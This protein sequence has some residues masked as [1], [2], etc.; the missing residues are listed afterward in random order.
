MPLILD[1]MKAEVGRVVAQDQPGK[2]LG[3]PLYLNK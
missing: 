1:T 3:R 2:K